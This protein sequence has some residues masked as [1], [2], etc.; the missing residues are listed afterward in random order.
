MGITTDPQWDSR[1]NNLSEDQLKKT[2]TIS[3]ED[4]FTHGTPAPPTAFDEI[5]TNLEQVKMLVIACIIWLLFITL[6][7]LAWVVYAIDRKRRKMKSFDIECQMNY[8]TLECGYQ[9][10]Y[11]NMLPMRR[12]LQNTED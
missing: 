8:D 2:P 1:S 6:I 5:R 7:I 10:I 12:L 4:Q 9:S 3:T 11:R